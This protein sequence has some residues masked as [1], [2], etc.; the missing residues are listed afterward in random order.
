MISGGYELSHTLVLY[1]LAIEL[2]GDI[3]QVK[4]LGYLLSRRI[5]CYLVYSLP[6]TSHVKSTIANFF[7]FVM[8]VTG[9][10]TACWI[11]LSAC[12]I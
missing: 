8:P 10:K 6:H 3:E 7:I 4:L 2:T 12:T 1:A 9:T 11:I 5:S